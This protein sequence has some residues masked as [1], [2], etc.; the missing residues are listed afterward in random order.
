[1]KNVLIVSAHFP[2]LNTMAAKRYGYMCKYMEE[3]GYKPY[4]LTQRARGGA[5][6]NVKMDLALP[7]FKEQIIRIGELG[8]NL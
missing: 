2:P 7:V 3:N 5:Y 8:I 6:L 1:M 4:I